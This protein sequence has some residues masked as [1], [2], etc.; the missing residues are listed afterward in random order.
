MLNICHVI[1]LINLLQS[2]QTE[3]GLIA[4]YTETAS[5]RR[6]HKILI[7]LYIFSLLDSITQ[8]P[9]HTHQFLWPFLWVTINKQN[10]SPINYVNHN[11]FYTRIAVCCVVVRHREVA[12]LASSERAH[13]S[14]VIIK[15]NSHYPSFQHASICDAWRDALIKYTY[16]SDVVVTL[17]S[18]SEYIFLCC[19]C[20]DYN[21]S[22][23]TILSAC[24]MLLLLLLWTHHERGFVVFIFA[25]T[26]KFRYWRNAITLCWCMYVVCMCVAIRDNKFINNYKQ[27]YK[28]RIGFHIIYTLKM[29]QMHSV[30]SIYT[31]VCHRMSY[32]FIKLFLV[33][34]N[35]FFLNLFILYIVKNILNKFLMRFICI[36]IL[37]IQIVVRPAAA[38][39]VTVSSSLL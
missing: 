2:A 38:A 23:Y 39:T 31:I 33:E 28:L 11:I 37:Y 22:A 6:S 36:H 10:A 27:P 35:S 26:N 15:Y 21:A 29:Q 14:P 1:I 13:D 34:V 4:F 7:I 9:K 5:S 17:S 25:L 32:F 18:Y 19:V 30:T 8:N 24:L 16:Y 12:E 3:K 20:F